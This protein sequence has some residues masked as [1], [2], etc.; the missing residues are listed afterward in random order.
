[1]AV[2]YD[3]E[4]E[5]GVRNPHE[6][7]GIHTDLQL[8]DRPERVTKAAQDLRARLQ[9]TVLG[10]RLE[11]MR[12]VYGYQCTHIR[13]SKSLKTRGALDSSSTFRSSSLTD[14]IGGN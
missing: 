7:G 8:Q 4:Q 13:H 10:S 9:R 6:L 11:H 2:G 3:T 1:M 5:T 14:G 12:V